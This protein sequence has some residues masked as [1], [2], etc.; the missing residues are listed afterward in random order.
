[1]TGY[2]IR[3]RRIAPLQSFSCYVRDADRPR[4]LLAQHAR[5]APAKIAAKGRLDSAGRVCIPRIVDHLN[6]IGS[7]RIQCQIEAVGGMRLAAQYDGSR[8]AGNT[9]EHAIDIR[10]MTQ[11]LPRTY[12]MR[13]VCEQHAFSIGAG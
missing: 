7:P 2:G 6:S 3:G 8:P 11:V 10:T 5:E 12:K 1:M 13:Q 4:A 9:V